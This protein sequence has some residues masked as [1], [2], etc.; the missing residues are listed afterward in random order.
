MPSVK[1]YSKYTNYPRLFSNTYWG[2]FATE[3][4][5]DAQ[6]V[7]NRNK[8]VQEYGILKHRQDYPKYLSRIFG[9]KNGFFEYVGDFWDHVEVYET[10]NTYVIVSSPYVAAG[11][12][13]IPVQFTNICPIYATGATT[14][15]AVIPKRRRR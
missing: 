15:A 10:P 9:F 8:F 11:F 4:G 5:P 14:F 6:I 7:A 2:N 3:N 1:K 12:D 13:E